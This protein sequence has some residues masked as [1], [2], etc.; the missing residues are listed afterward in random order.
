MTAWNASVL[1]INVSRS[2]Q[3]LFLP[4][5]LWTLDKE[6]HCF[7][8][9]N[10]LKH[11]P[12]L[13]RNVLVSP[14]LTCPQVILRDKEFGVDWKKIRTEYTFSAF[15]LSSHQLWSLEGGRI[16]VCVNDIPLLTKTLKS[17]VLQND[18]SALR[19]VTL[20]CTIISLLCLVI[21]FITYCMFPILRT[22]PG[23]NNMCLVVSLFLAQFLMI[24]RPSFSSTGLAIVSALS[25]FSWLSM[26]LWLQV[27]SF[28]MYRVFSAKSRSE[29][30]G[31][32]NRK[33]MIQYIFYAFGSSLLIVIIN[34][35]ATLI[36]TEGENTGYDR[37]STLMMY[38]LAFIV[39][40]ITPLCFVCVTNV[41]FYILTAYKIHSTPT[42]E[43]TTR[44]RVHFAIYVKLFSLTGLSWILQIIDT[45]VAFSVL[46]YFVA[47]LNGLQGLFIFVS[48][49]CN[50]R[51][52]KLYK[53]KLHRFP[54]HSPNSTVTSKRE[55][56]SM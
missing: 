28:H 14:L 54:V 44:N 56:T 7:V 12:S 51:V 42:I 47:I 36:V 18:N 41:M 38:K 32:Q 22:L 39:T 35:F 33:I 48:Y 6:I 43:K 23:I 24:V 34:I 31:N 55:T 25:H 15:S 40:L 30:N 27:C 20:I 50:Q 46:S 10:E 4:S 26:F 17:R 37:V 52:W 13:Y 53:N 45:F 2:Q 5:Y 49:V 21:T 9:A 29:F 3:S 19:I 1:D 16:R 8:L 11:G